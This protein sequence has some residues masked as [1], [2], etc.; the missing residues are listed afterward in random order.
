MLDDPA[1]MPFRAVVESANDAIIITGPDLD[2]PGPTILYVNKAFTDLT[3][4][5]ANEVIGMSPR[6]F[7][8]PRITG[9]AGHEAGEALRRGEPVHTTALNYGKGG[10]RYWVDIKIIPLRDA[11]GNITHFAAIERDITEIKEQQDQLR[12]LAEQDELTG[13]ANRR[14]FLSAMRAEM[15]RALRYRH[16]LSMLMIDIDHFKR[17][18]DTWGHAAGDQVLKA[19]AETCVGGLRRMD[20]VGRIGGE[21]FAVM[22][23]ETGANAA[24]D[25]GERLREAVSGIKVLVTSDSRPIQ[26]TCSIGAAGLDHGGDTVDRL[27]ARADRALYQAKDE[28]R[29]RLCAA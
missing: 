13:V 14:H 18:N 15:G 1:S 19:L 8:G 28:G 2:F 23:P 26:I 29:N 21:E 27:M 24:R 5:T 17:V 22:L 11:D 6:M 7:Q 16:P 20:L 9:G 10:R 25:T 4:Y 3:G 12:K